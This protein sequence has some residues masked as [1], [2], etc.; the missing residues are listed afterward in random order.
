MSFHFDFNAATI[1]E[2]NAIL[3]EEVMP[4][5]VKA[6]VKQGLQAFPDSAVHVKAIGHLWN[7]DYNVS[8]AEIKVE[9]IFMRTPKRPVKE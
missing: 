9:K 2:A 1:E 6:F 5:G 7:K 4:D 8:A 3:E